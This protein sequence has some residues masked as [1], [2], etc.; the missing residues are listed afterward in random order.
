MNRKFK[1]LL[2]AGILAVVGSAAIPMTVQKSNCGGNSWALSEVRSI[3]AFAFIQANDAP[4]RTFRFDS[5]NPRQCEYLSINPRG[6]HFLVSGQPLVNSETEPRRIVVVCDRP[7]NNVPQRTFFS[8]PYT[9]AVGYSD[10]TSGLISTREFAALDL[11]KFRALDELFP[12]VA[13]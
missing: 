2:L 8:A 9:H 1:V 4:D 12:A 11:T 13:K 6:V 10:G 7:F 3:A 5:A